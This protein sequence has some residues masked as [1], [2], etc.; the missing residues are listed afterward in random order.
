[1]GRRPP[2][3][4]DRR[5]PSQFV[6]EEFQ[7]NRQVAQGAAGQEAG[8]HGM[9]PP[10]ALQHAPG[11]DLLRGIQHPGFTTVEQLFR[12]LPEEGWFSPNLNPSKPVKFEFGGFRVPENETFLITDYQFLPLRLSG[13][14]PFDFVG[15]APYR[16][17]GYMGFDI[18]VNRT[19]L[20]SLFYQLDPAPVQF[21]RESFVAPTGR[22]TTAQFNKARANAFG[23]T[24]GEGASLL[25]ARPNVQGARG[26]PFTMIAGPGT[27]VSLSCVIFRRI[28]APLAG[29]QGSVSGYTIASTVMSSLFNRVRPR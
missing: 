9:G 5:P 11:G 27:S 4:V 14:D 8:P 10:P 20:S 21:F 17:S 16:F 13:L 28:M 2:H 6:A 19:R 1:M 15:A 25:P 26:M 7:L 22:V 29:I 3:I 12:V 18:A 23:S 24:A